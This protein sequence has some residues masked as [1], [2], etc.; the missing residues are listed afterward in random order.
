MAANP[1]LRCS[2]PPGGAGTDFHGA[3]LLLLLRSLATGGAERQAVVLATELHRR[4]HHVAI[5]L[6]Y[7]G[8]ALL[9]ELRKAGVPVY[10]LG[11]RGRWDILPFV[12]RLFDLVQ[13]ERPTIVHG[14][15]PMPNL[16]CSLLKLRFAPLRVVW[17]VRASNMQGARYDW[18]SNLALALERHAARTA[19]LVIFNSRAAR[20]FH[21]AGGNA[22]DKFAVVHNGI[23][24]NRF[25]PDADARAALRRQL[26]VMDDTPLVGLVG[27]LDPMK[28]HPTFLQA[29]AKLRKS[30]PRVRFLCVGDGSAEARHRLTALAT[31]LGL[32][33]CLTWRESCADVQAIYAGLDLLVSSSSYGEG[34]S[35]A[36][37]EAMATAVPCVVTDVGDS[38]LIV[39]ELGAVVPPR[40]PA[41]LAQACA[42]MLDRLRKEPDLGR[43]C[44]QRIETCFS[45]ARLV[46]R[47]SALLGLTSAGGAA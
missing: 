41:A 43:L 31:K 28:D 42:S 8:G 4:G 44:R 36:V 25:R 15:L 40:D 6:F 16:L 26:G 1:G 7:D 3:R 27:R 24:T 18:M 45:L 35:N 22:D 46:E 2:T 21:L 9:D 39:G 29:A 19:D 33:S 38:A 34:F 14:Y 23:D 10:V 5:C 37:G 20:A 47:T 13:R 30:L 32:D 11:K 12:R 17:G